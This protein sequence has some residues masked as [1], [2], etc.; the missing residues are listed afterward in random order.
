MDWGTG[1]AI[2]FLIWWTVVFCVLPWGIRTDLQAGTGA[3]VNPALKKKFLITTGISLLVWMLVYGVI[4]A[5]FIDFRAL[6]HQMVEE[7]SR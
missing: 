4:K 1:I 2:Y 6:S 7:D 5:D 3:P